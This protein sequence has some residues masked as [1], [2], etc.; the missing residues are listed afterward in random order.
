MESLRPD[1]DEVDNFQRS[2]K[3]GKGAEKPKVNPEVR[4]EKVGARAPKP[5]TPITVWLMMI[6]IAT[7]V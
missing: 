2:R 5:N 4:A 7:V 1:R 3:T 6:V